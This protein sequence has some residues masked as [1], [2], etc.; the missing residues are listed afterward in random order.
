MLDAFYQ[1]AVVFFMAYGVGYMLPPF[2]CGDGPVA[3]PLP[4]SE[5]TQLNTCTYNK[6]EHIR[7][8]SQA[9]C[10]ALCALQLVIHFFN[11]Q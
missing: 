9:G 7:M 5:H 6:Q 3:L 1:S 2:L 11:V 4:I 10:P 8:G